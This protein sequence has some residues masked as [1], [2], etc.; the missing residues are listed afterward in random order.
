MAGTFTSAYLCEE[1][2]DSPRI[3]AE[4][5]RIALTLEELAGGRVTEVLPALRTLVL[6]ETLPSGV[7]E[8]IDKFVAARELAGHPIAISPWPGKD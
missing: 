7:Q 3:N 6:E 5:R 2:P 8:T 4:N 1:S